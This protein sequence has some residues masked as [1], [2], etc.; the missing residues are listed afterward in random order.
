[1]AR[2]SKLKEKSKAKEVKTMGKAHLP[3]QKLSRRLQFPK[4]RKWLLE[5]LLLWMSRAAVP[6]ETVPG[7]AVHG[8][9]RGQAAEAFAGSIT[10]STRE[11]GVWF[12][13]E[14]EEPRAAIPV[15]TPE[16]E[17][18]VS[19]MEKENFELRDLND[20]LQS[21]HNTLWNHLLSTNEALR[22]QNEKIQLLNNELR[23]QATNASP[24]RCSTA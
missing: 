16:L 9:E 13:P 23:L 5:K 12:E 15:T 18:D 10:I 8:E 24:A 4:L 3:M 11:V 21:K 7:I 6:D 20:E 1:M 19:M 2:L 14:I 17:D 22:N